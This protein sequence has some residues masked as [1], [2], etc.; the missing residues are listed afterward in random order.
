M[1]NLRRG[2]RGASGRGACV[3][4]MSRC[5][6]VR[7]RHGR[8]GRVA[9]LRAIVSPG[10]VPSRKSFCVSCGTPWQAPADMQSLRGECMKSLDA[11]ALTQVGGECTCRSDTTCSR[12]GGRCGAALQ[13][14]CKSGWVGAG[15]VRT[16]LSSVTSGMFGSHP[17]ELWRR[18]RQNRIPVSCAFMTIVVDGLLRTVGASFG[19][20]GAQASVRFHRRH[21][22][23]GATT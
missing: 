16:V 17:V 12:T 6:H 2:A 11:H 23:D 19:S 3:G 4:S 10:C 15:R 21:A 14:V 22:G 20:L 9:P 1:D 13:Q 8:W 18:W 7:S 5:L